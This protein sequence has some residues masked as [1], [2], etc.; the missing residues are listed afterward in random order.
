MRVRIDRPT[1]RK[2]IPADLEGIL[3][4]KRALPMPQ[5]DHTYSGGFLIGCDPVAYGGL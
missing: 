1:L 5:G 2:G 3:A 4:V